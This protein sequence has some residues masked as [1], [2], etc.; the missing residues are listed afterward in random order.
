M[1]FQIV[2]LPA[3]PFGALA[4]LDAAELAQLHVHRMSADEPDSYPCRVSLRYADPGDELLLLNHEHQSANSPYRA[5]GPIFVRVGHSTASVAPGEV[6]S[7]L[8]KALLSVRGYGSEGWIEFADVCEG[9]DLEA[10]I[11]R[12][13][14]SPGVD[15]LHLHFARPGCY[16]CRVERRPAPDAQ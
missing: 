1:S 14:K 8:R 15:Y 12:A 7:M 4:N 11:V 5:R 13:F 16:I 2:A 10:T 3:E 9:R 6:P